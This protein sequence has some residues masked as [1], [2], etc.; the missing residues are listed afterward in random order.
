MISRTRIK[1]IKSLNLKKYRK[2]Y[3][4][5][6]A[7]GVVNVSDFL[8]SGLKPEYFYITEKGLGKIDKSL[9]PENLA[10][11]GSKDMERITLLKN[12]S[13]VLA[14]FPLPE[15]RSLDLKSINDYVLMLDD[16]KDPGNLGTIIRTADWFG[17]KNIVCSNETVDVYNP[18]VVQA[19]MGSLSRVDVF[20]HDI[21]KLLENSGDIEIYGAF[22]NGADIKEVEKQE[23]GVIIIGS[24]AHGISTKVEP[25]VTKKIT[26]PRFKNS[27]TGAES[28]NASIA[29][30]IICYEFRR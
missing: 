11:V 12:P 7:E 19:T 2:S 26:I 17:I 13:E 8:K 10:T 22:L 5:F 4:L 28:L 27:K 29:T 15:N 1:L 9:L 21:V 25:Y 23:K 30:A 24:E 16:I 20:Y 14:V 6:V 18:K 3:G